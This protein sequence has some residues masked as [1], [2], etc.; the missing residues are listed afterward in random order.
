MRIDQ[1]VI[2]IDIEALKVDLTSIKNG[3]AQLVLAAALFRASA[4]QLR[5]GFEVEGSRAGVCSIS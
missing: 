4:S 5:Q 2:K 3:R 1:T